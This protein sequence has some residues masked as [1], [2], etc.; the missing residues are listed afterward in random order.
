MFAY[1][2]MVKYL[3]FIVKDEL[4]IK[5][6]VFTG[7]NPYLTKFKHIYN[8]METGEAKDFYGVVFSR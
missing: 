7:R 4:E 3:N 5:L 2:T 8:R 1:K 6:I